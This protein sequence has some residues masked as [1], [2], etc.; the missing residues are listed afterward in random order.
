MHDIESESLKR[1]LKQSFIRKALV[2]EKGSE[3]RLRGAAHI[4]DIPLSD[5]ERR[6]VEEYAIN[7][8]NAAAAAKAAGYKWPKHYAY[9][10]VRAPKVR[11]AIE[12]RFKDVIMSADE[13][14]A[15]L[16]EQARGDY[17]NYIDAEGNVDI[18]ALKEDGKA[19]LIKSISDSKYGKRIEFYDAQRAMNLMAKYHRLF[20]ER[21]E[22][23]TFDM[24][25]LT[26][27]QLERLANGDKLIDV[28]LNREDYSI[29]I[30]DS[31]VEGEEAV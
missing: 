21:I 25:R 23:I 10:L 14:L 24:S 28:L 4:E 9:R 27:Q 3:I 1:D 16:T 8:F 31:V 13:V 6:F 18:E 7:G 15:R 2:S 17:G 19:H 5:Q 30:E 20:A 11:A 26:D 29:T 22:N 12:I